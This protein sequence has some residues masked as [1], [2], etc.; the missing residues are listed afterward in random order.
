MP[1]AKKGPKQWYSRAKQFEAMASQLQEPERQI[2]PFETTVEF[3][4]RWAA[5]KVTKARLMRES[6]KC[7]VEGGRID[8][9]ARAAMA[10]SGVKS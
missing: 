5:F 2:Q 6:H 10:A 3:G 8:V 9:K 4:E 7:W 1:V